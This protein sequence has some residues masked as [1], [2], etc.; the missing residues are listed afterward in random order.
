MTRIEFTVPVKTVNE[1]NG[2]HQNWRVVS[3]RRKHI[4][5]TTAWSFAGSPRETWRPIVASAGPGQ[6]VVTM[7]RISSGTLDPHDGLPASL[8]SVVDGIA[9]GLGLAKDSDPR[10]EWRYAQAKG[11]RGEFGVRVVVELK[12]AV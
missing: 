11:K 3:A 7:T 10:V 5:A 4:R 6:V 12:E 2:S 8:K 1:L 9:D